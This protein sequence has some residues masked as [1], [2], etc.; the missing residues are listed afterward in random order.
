MSCQFFKYPQIAFRKQAM[1]IIYQ[2]SV[3]ADKYSGIFAFNTFYDRFG[4]S[5]RRC[6]GGFIEKFHS[7]FFVFRRRIFANLAGPAPMTK[8]LWV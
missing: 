7:L 5:F 1:N 3:L 2:I 6:P 8:N 4:G